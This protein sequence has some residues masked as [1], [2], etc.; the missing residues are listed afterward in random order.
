MLLLGASAALAAIHITGI[1]AWLRVLLA[2]VVI[3]R[4]WRQF[5]RIQQVMLLV[6]DDSTAQWSVYTVSKSDTPGATERATAPACGLPK[7]ANG[8]LVAAGYR[9][10]G[11]VVLAIQESTG[12]IRRVPIWRDQVS[13]AQFSYLHQQLAYAAGPVKHGSSRQENPMK[14]R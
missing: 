11:F 2:I 7:L 3:A 4:T 8:N 12:R 13:Q 10:A 14:I 6:H 1:P 9:S 5:A